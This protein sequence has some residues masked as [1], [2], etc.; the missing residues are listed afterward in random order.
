MPYL[1]KQ[2]FAN[3]VNAKRFEID[4]TKKGTYLIEAEYHEISFEE[5][6]RLRDE[7]NLE[8]EEGKPK[9]E[10][11]YDDSVKHCPICRHMPP[12]DYCPQCGAEGI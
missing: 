5:L 7:L 4:R 8:I 3:R 2:I 12:G 6:V 1:V 10:G 11:I 9:A